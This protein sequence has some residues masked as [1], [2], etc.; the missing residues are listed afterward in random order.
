MM[1]DFASE[2]E[3][4]ESRF[5]RVDNAFNTLRKDLETQLDVQ[6][7]MIRS[8]MLHMGT[9]AVWEQMPENEVKNRYYLLLEMKQ[10]INDA[11]ALDNDVYW[12]LSRA[13]DVE[14]EYSVFRKAMEDYIQKAYP[15]SALVEKTKMDPSG[16]TCYV[17]PCYS[18]PALV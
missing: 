10:E 5:N 15:G 3:E 9:T 8:S 4:A 6:L 2:L 14:S 18:T 11:I 16:Y 13:I 12:R 1:A 17:L 7:S